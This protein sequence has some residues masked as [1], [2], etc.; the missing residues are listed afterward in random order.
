MKTRVILGISLGLAM[1][2]WAYADA[3]GN[4]PAAIDPTRL[5]SIDAVLH[6]CRH[7]DP[8]GSSGYRAL[9]VAYFGRHSDRAFDVVEH[10]PQYHAAFTQIR[11]VLG[12]APRDWALEGCR[13]IL[14][15]RGGHQ[16]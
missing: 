8:D 2:S 11:G 9:R 10:T 6:F 1:S 12:A 7:I 14:P 4:R 5:G 13:A 15:G 3:P 16:R